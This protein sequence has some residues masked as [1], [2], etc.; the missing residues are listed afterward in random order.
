MRKLQFVQEFIGS[1]LL[2]IQ[3]KKVVR[4][5]QACNF[6]HAKTIGIVYDAIDQEQHK[7]VASF[8]A[9]LMET[10]GSQVQMV[11]FVSN[12]ELTSAFSGQFGCKYITKKDFTWYGDEQNCIISDFIKTQFDILIDISVESIYPLLYITQ[13]STA[14]FKVGRFCD[15][16]MHLDLLIDVK[17][18]ESID[19]LINQIHVYLSMIKVNK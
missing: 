8:A 7:K 5:L 19:Y 15:K 6:E 18:N 11:G 9:M 2:K 12:A 10:Y 1:Y 4:E 14:K 13:L 16:N 3:A 17:N